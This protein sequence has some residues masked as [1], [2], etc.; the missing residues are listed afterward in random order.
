[1]TLARWGRVRDDISRA[2]VVVGL[3]ECCERL[4]ELRTILNELHI[5]RNG[6][7]VWQGPMV[8]LEYEHD[9]LRIFAEDVLWQATRSVVYPGYDH[10]WPNSTLALDTVDILLNQCYSRQGDPWNML[11]GHLHPIRT[12]GE[13]RH[14]RVCNDWQAYVWEEV[15]KF[16]EDYGVDYTV[17]GRDIYYWDIHWEWKRLES[18]QEEWIGDYP[19]IVEYGNQLYTRC[20]VTN[21]QGWAGVDEIGLPATGR[22]S[23]GYVD[24]LINNATEE[25][26]ST[27]PTEAQLRSWQESAV[28]NLV[29][30]HP[31]PLGIVVPANTTLL[32]G[33][34]WRV[35]DLIPGAW[36][37]VSV[38]RLC[39]EVTEWQRLHAMQVEELAGQGETVT[40]TAQSA[41]REHHVVKP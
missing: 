12:P 35:E 27:K 7:M 31:A 25:D 6:E 13:P 16:A 22:N 19:R 15:D 37:Q 10:T 32:P 11:P 26:V 5:Y 30:T 8:R 21:G 36:F 29:D 14:T 34:P 1:L 39:R 23:Y 3:T 28:K 40:F 33:A 4:E 18:L 38:T 41:P 20:V 24:K 9:N 17:V 2:E